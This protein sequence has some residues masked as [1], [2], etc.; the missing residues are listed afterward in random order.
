M[1]ALVLS[2]CG[3]PASA[4]L[5][6]A[7]VKKGDLIQ[8][9]TASG[10]SVAQN[11]AKLSFKTAG[12]L[13]KLDV[14]AGDMVTAG[15]VLAELDPADLQA[16]A[17]QAESAKQAADA[18][19]GA[20]QARVQQLL[21]SA[22]PENIAQA[23]AAADSAR[24]KLQDML[25]GGRPEQVSQAQSQ[26]D[27]AQ[28]KLQ[29]VQNGS[30][31]EQIQQAQAAVQAAQAK[32]QALQNGPRPEQVAVL[33]KQIDAAKNAL[34]AAQTARDGACNH[35]NPDYV[36]SSANAQ[37]NAAQTGVDTATKQL[38]LATAPPT[39]T[40][41]QAAQSAVDQAK[42][43]LALLQNGNTPQDVQAAKD[44]VDQAQQGV[45]LAKSPYTQAQI[46]Q[47]RDAVAQA[48][49]AAALAAHPFTDADVAAAQAGV[50]QAQAQANQASAAV[51]AAHLNL[52][53]AKL[54]APASGKVLQVN[55]VAG[56]LVS[57]N[58]PLFVLGL[59][60][61]VVN[62]GLPETAVARVKAGQ[63][64]SVTFDS[65]PGKPLSAKVID[66]SPA[67]STAQNLVTYVA[68]IKLDQPDDQVRPGMNASV[69]IYTLHRQDVLLVP[70]GAVQSYQGKDIVMLLNGSQQQQT[71]VQTGASDQQS[72]E[73][74]SGVSEGQHVLLISKPLN[75]VSLNPGAAQ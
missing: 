37:V 4:T 17:Q 32:L 54:T 5:P 11:Q 31:Q 70:N 46:Q 44:A 13:A 23:N 25:A 73:I 49:A 60:D 50:Q 16:A 7:T 3:V 68:T 45:A 21:A 48:D 69:T 35:F 58:S 62:V 14:N 12:K 28:Q 75:G 59:G 2:G 18:A 63:D 40:D 38:Q 9:A 27:A 47:A 10:T 52:S 34:Y 56:E 6:S 64:A 65:V 30:R 74:V 33:Q 51:D 15:Q 29:A 61:T 24:A 8:T 67:P 72:T 43:Q 42:A 41:L 1:A 71:A 39:Q 53:Y 66:I 57:A 36:C 20:A 22:K 19:V 26:L 55:G